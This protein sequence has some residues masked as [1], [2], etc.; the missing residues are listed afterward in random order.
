MNSMFSNVTAACGLLALLLYDACHCN[1]AV[2]QAW[3][4]QLTAAA[5]CG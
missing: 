5:D 2:E 3:L 4:L 1:T